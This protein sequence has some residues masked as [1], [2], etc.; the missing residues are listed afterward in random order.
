MMPG[1]LTRAR[2]LTLQMH[3]LTALPPRVPPHGGQAPHPHVMSVVI[4]AHRGE[5]ICPK[6]Y[7]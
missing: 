3:G 2:V 5:V 6:T 1:R 7:S 4:D